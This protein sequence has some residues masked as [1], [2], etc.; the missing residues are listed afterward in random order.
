MA[1]TSDQKS[2]NPS[3]I[4]FFE[5]L[6]ITLSDITPASSVFVIIPTILLTTGTGILWSF[7]IGTVLSFAV[8][9][10]MAELG[11][12]YPTAGGPY[13]MIK[14]TLGNYLGILAMACAIG[15]AVFLP[16]AIGMGVGTYLHTFFPSLNPPLIGFFT[17]V[18]AGF[19]AIIPIS[20]NSIIMIAFLILELIAIIVLSVIGFAH[21]HRPVSVLLSEPKAMT[22]HGISPISMGLILAGVTTVLFAFH[23]YEQIVTL[24]EETRG[25]RRLVGGMLL[26]ALAVTVIFEVTPSIAVTLGGPDLSKLLSTNAPVSYMLTANAGKAWN[27]VV[28]I[29]AIIAI[30]NATIAIILGFSRILYSTAREQAWPPRISKALARVH[31]KWR[32]PW[33]ATVTIGGIGGLLSLAS[34]FINLVDFTAVLISGIYGLLAIGAFVSRIRHKGE[35]PYRMP[36]WPVPPIIAFAGIILGLSQ[37]P[38]R[39]LII[40]FGILLVFSLYYLLYLRR[41]SSFWTKQDQSA[42]PKHQ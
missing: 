11:S 33:V 31:P 1:D 39:D 9:L 20:R 41:N 5:N 35:R 34:E 18:V 22:D 7:L 25:S 15:Q 3:A 6:G 28:I 13:Y 16:S 27:T 29:G 32:T 23:G 2:L 19:I 24:S 30:F 37:Q 26:A 4:S 12:I 17:M 40:G 21:I 10:C 38:P 42:S 36:L 14:R 8:A